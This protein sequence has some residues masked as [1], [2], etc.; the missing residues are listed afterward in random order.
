[1]KRT[2]VRHF[3]QW[4]RKRGNKRADHAWSRHTGH[5]YDRAD[6]LVWA[7]VTR[8]DRSQ[9]LQFAMIQK[10]RPRDNEVDGSEEFGDLSDVPF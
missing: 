4:D 1:L 10:F 5:V 2:L 3:Q 9:R 8:K 7:L 6:V